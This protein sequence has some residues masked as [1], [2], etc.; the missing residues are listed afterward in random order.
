MPERLDTRGKIALF[1]LLKAP[2]ASNESTVAEEASPYLT[3]S[4][5]EL[6][7]LVEKVHNTVVAA[8]HDDF[9]GNVAKENMVKGA[10]FGVVQDMDLT[11]K[12]FTLITHQ[13][14]Y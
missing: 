9:R 1:N 3:H 12:L 2:Q 14:E 8:K 11:E 6:V 5:E 13:D 4:D 7:S 10:I